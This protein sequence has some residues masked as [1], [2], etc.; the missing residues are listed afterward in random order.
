LVLVLLTVLYFLIWFHY[1]PPLPLR[2]NPIE[3]KPFTRKGKFV[4]IVFC[5]TVLMW[6]TDSIHGIP[7]AVVA[8]F[9]VITFTATGMLSAKEF[10]RIEWNILFI[11]AGGLS[12]G[13]GM[14]LSGLD[15]V[16][17]GFL[18]VESNWIV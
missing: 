5:F 12:L 17:L 1:K 15:K 2:L 14:N 9:P 10:N 18:P 13:Q 3:K 16:L 4:I 11:I 7:A 8:L 6:L